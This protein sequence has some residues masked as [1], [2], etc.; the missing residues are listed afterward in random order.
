MWHLFMAF[1]DTRPCVIASTY[2][3]HIHLQPAPAMDGKLGGIVSASLHD[4]P[5]ALHAAL[6][7]ALKCTLALHVQHSLVLYS[8]DSLNLLQ[9]VTPTLSCQVRLSTA[10]LAAL[11]LPACMNIHLY[12]MPHCQ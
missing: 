3:V 9:P 8:A 12:C 10:G 6:H 11:S 7:C 2:G 5:L 4:H 1:H